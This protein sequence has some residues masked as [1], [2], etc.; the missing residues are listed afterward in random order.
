MV[1][2]VV[3]GGVCDCDRAG[4]DDGGSDGSYESFEF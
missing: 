3:S 4:G 1:M 2:T